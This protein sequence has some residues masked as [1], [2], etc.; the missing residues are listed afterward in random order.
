MD[1]FNRIKKEM[2]AHALKDF[3]RECVGLVTKDMQYIPCKNISSTPKT[4]FFLDPEALVVND[5]NIFG[6]F[7]S[8]PGEEDPIPSKEDK[9]STMFSEYK[10]FVGFINKIYTYWY[11]SNVHALKFE[12][13]ESKHLDS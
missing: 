13:F 7:H 9:M 3:P 8:H 6:I 11:D 2:K 10:F 4:T 5:G 1:T 12:E